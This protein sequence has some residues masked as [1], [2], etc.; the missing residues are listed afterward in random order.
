MLNPNIKPD[1]SDYEFEQE[2]RSL[3]YDYWGHRSK[4]DHDKWQ[5]SKPN[6]LFCRLRDNYAWYWLSSFG[7]KVSG[8]YWWFHD[9]H[10]KSQEIAEI[11]EVLSDTAAVERWK[12]EIGC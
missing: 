5:D 2:F 8:P 1:D 7:E 6:F 9:L 4:E 10:W 3:D 12:K 11:D